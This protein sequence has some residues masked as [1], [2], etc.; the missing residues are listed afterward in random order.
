VFVV[1]GG[2]V[3]VVPAPWP[4]AP[5]VPG[6]P[7]PVEPALSL[8]PLL[9]VPIVGEVVDVAPAPWPEAPV[10]PGL[11][12]PVAPIAELPL[13]SPPLLS[14]ALHAVNDRLI[15]LLM[16]RACIVFMIISYN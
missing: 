7:V 1:V 5:V 6:L 12:V 2:V 8:W 4:E 9:V 11:P 15:M 16:R 3:D 10:V 13:V 14:I